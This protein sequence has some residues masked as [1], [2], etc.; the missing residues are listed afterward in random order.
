MFSKF[1][2]ILAPYP[3][4][5]FFVLKIFGFP[6]LSFLH[7]EVDENR[8]SN[9][10]ILDLNQAVYR[11]LTASPSLQIAKK[12]SSA[13]YFS[14]KQAQLAPSPILS[15]EIENFSGRRTWKGWNH[16]EESYIWSQLFETGDKRQIRTQ[17]ASYR[18]YAAMVGYD[19]S[20]LILLNRL[21]RAFIQVA[22]NQ[23]FLKN[24]IQQSQI[25]KEML[26]IATK[27]VEAGKVS[28]IQQNKAQVAYSVTLINSEKAQINLKNAKRR[29]S[30]LW[31][32]TC[33]DFKTVLFP[34]FDLEMPKELQTYIEDLC[35][36]PEITQLLY[37]F[38]N[39]K[40]HWRLEK[41]NRLPDVTMQVGYK[42]NYEE[43][44]QG[45]IAG[46]S[47]P[48]PIFNQNQGNISEAYFEMLKVDDQKRWL[49]LT[50][51]SKLSIIHEEFNR[52]YLEAQ[53]I[54]SKTLPL[55][56]Q[57]FELAYKGYLEGKF[58]YLEVLDAQRTLFEITENYIQTLIN[59]HTKRADMDYLNSQLD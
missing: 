12:E 26:D 10:L 27:K 46:V 5:L 24:A 3:F 2:K 14:V 42:I 48:I 36:Q 50:L 44:N 13:K 51:Q 49:A 54:Q 59:Y 4:F 55:A 1:V 53:E 16:R 38:Q 56:K 45:L 8:E 52:S 18:Y 58:E 34:F 37:Q 28:L 23:E 9:F 32:E 40:H 7:A 21:H 25:A 15:Y 6:T 17:A 30:L 31:A 33:P 47:I 57:A 35:N 43:K 39:A 29:L 11:V 20:K 19:I 41:A 22:A